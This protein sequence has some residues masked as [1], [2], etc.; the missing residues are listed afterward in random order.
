MANN[1]N[2]TK[3]DSPN[4][5]YSVGYTNAKHIILADK[6]SPLQ[7]ETG[8]VLDDIHVEYETYGTLNFKKNNAILVV[9]ALSGDAHAA[10]WD[11]NWKEKKRPWN[12][13][14]P[15]WWDSVIGP[16]KALDTNDFFII[17]SN[18]LGSCFGTTGPMD[19][20][21]NSN[22]PWGLDFPVVTIG[23]WVTLQV[24]LIDAL[25]IDK[26][27]G[28]VGGSLGGQQVIEW[29]MAYPN[30]VQKCAV[31]ATAPKLSTQGL[32]FNAVGR[33]SILNDPGFLGGQYYDSVGPQN[34]LAAARMLAH[35]T[36]LSEQ[37]MDN[38]FGRR[39]QDKKNPDFDFGI[40]FEV[41]SYLNYQGKSFIEKFDA[42]SYLYIT[43]AMDYYD[44]ATKWGN[45][46]IK[47]A[48]KCIKSDMLVMT[49]S[50]DWLYSPTQGRALAEAIASSGREVTYVTV[51]SDYGHDA[52]LVEVE[53]VTR[54]LS[55]FFRG[56]KIEN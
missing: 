31:L 44:A 17:C 33:H 49:F 7:L 43:R 18:G 8:G 21:P 34:G 39:L 1:S 29:S 42:N 14:K 46:D 35:I 38:K 26:L 3:Y 28:V 13:K 51:D 2:K 53:Q 22:K 54:L 15:G 10:G 25:G 27:F 11:E 41:E 55:S 30:R 52:F 12:K 47:K 40:E 4:S 48:V 20:N 23:D 32:A 56:D 45:G 50:T 9:H 36:Y 16:G 24:R 6:N 5:P 19:I 37:A